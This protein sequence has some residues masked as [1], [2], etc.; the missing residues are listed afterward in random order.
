MVGSFSFDRVKLIFSRVDDGVA[1]DL[2]GLI[3]T[4]NVR[5]WQVTRKL[6]GDARM[7]FSFGFPKVPSLVGLTWK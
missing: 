4:G 7:L 5:R 6:V 2:V 3:N 1:D